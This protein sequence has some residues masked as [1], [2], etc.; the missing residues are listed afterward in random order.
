MAYF[1][2]TNIFFK[3]LENGFDKNSLE[4]INNNLLLSNVDFVRSQKPA[5]YTCPQFSYLTISADG[6]MSLG[7][8]SRLDNREDYFGDICEMSLEDIR[9][10]RNNLEICQK[11][12]KEAYDFFIHESSKYDRILLQSIT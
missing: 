6:E 4:F 8:C 11:C 12:Q 7:C 2:S 1:N 9:N 5:H 10:A 3:Y